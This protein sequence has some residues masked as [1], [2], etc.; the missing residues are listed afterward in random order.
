MT[1]FLYIHKDL[2]VMCGIISV[3]DRN[4]ATLHGWS[5]PINRLASANP[6]RSLLPSSLFQTSEQVQP[7]RSRRIEPHQEDIEDVL[8]DGVRR[9]LEAEGVEGRAAAR[10][11]GKA[12]RAPR[13][14]TDDER[15]ATAKLIEQ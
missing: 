4:R 7:I 10:P 2:A 6:V 15:Q 5:E 1:I 3:G 8:E 14:A 13:K 9:S 11:R 12:K